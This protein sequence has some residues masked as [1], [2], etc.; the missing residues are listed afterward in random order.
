[1]IQMPEKVESEAGVI[2]KI[3]DQY[4][5]RIGEALLIEMSHIRERVEQEANAIVAKAN[6][7]SAT[8]IAQAGRTG[9]VTVAT[10]MAG[11]GV[12]II[13]SCVGVPIGNKANCSREV[14]GVLCL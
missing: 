1:M 5:Q 7:E 13:P 2:Y 8:I 14:A 6:E 4:R 11:R 3:I 12:D 10:N 9:A